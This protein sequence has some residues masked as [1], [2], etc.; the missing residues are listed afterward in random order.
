MWL[1]PD[2]AFTAALIQMWEVGV[3]ASSPLEHSGSLTR[4]RLQPSLPLTWGAVKS[5]S[6]L[7]APIQR[8]LSPPRLLFQRFC[9]EQRHGLHSKALERPLQV[10]SFLCKPPALQQLD[11]NTPSCRDLTAGSNSTHSHREVFSPL[12]STVNQDDGVSGDM[13]Q[14]RP[15][16]GFT[17]LGPLMQAGLAL[18][19]LPH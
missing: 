16:L 19:L 4:A 7:D 3:L 14:G 13:R 17:A 1:C 2:W 10:G 12:Y 9:S 6:P 15:V 5:W 18:S 8:A 11:T